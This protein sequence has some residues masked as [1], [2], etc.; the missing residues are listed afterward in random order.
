MLLT[1]VLAVAAAAPTAPAK[2]HAY[3]VHDQVSLKRLA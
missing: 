2:P 3:T 1:L